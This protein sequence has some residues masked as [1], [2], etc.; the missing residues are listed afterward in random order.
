MLFGS[1]HL[2]PSGLNW[3]P[4]E[5][6]AAVAE[7]RRALVRDPDRRRGGRPRR[8]AAARPEARCRAGDTLAAHLPPGD[9]RPPPRGRRPRRPVGRGGGLHE[10]VAGG[11]DPL[12]R[13]GRPLRRAR[14]HRASSGRSTPSRRPGC[15]AAPWKAPPTRSASWP[16]A[17]WPSRSISSPSRST[18]S[19]R[20][21]RPTRGSW[22][23]GSPPTSPTS[24]KRRWTPCAPR[25]PRAYRALITDRNRRW[26]LEIERRLKRRGT[27][28]VV[29]GV[30]H[31]IGPDGLP[32][33][34]RAAGLKVEGPRNEA[35]AH[36]V[37]L[38]AARGLPYLRAS[39]F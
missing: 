19:K 8:P 15:A 31:L 27:I 22:T 13:R 5:L 30:G 14:R 33:V 4:A 38:T 18:R 35:S 34:F 25:R 17:R 32:S 20:S 6:D 3:R 1:I 21:R 7:R 28:V 11:R 12:H 29:V 2:L 26:A 9:A 36:R 16:T 24:D 23:H 10:A 39:R 37:R